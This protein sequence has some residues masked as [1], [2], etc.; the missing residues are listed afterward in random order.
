MSL[1]RRSGRIDV[2]AQGSSSEA[3]DASSGR[4]SQKIHGHTQ[5]PLSLFSAPK[6]DFLFSSLPGPD[7]IRKVLNK[8]CSETK[9]LPAVTAFS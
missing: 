7:R 4:K 1:R 8:R 5:T 3:G 6:P 2:T 9:K